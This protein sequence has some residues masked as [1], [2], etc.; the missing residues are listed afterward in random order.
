MTRHI[1]AWMKHSDWHHYVIVAHQFY[2][3]G[4]PCKV[5]D[6]WK[7][8]D[9]A[10]HVDSLKISNPNFRDERRIERDRLLMDC[11]RIRR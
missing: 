6:F 7:L 3:D 8:Y 5:F 1:E 2:K 10:A 11:V 9:T 4:K